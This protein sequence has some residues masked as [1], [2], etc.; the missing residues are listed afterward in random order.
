MSVDDTNEP[1]GSFITMFGRYVA[2]KL[3]LSRVVINVIQ[4]RKKKKEKVTKKKMDISKYADLKEKRIGKTSNVY[5][6]F[7]TS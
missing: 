1:I 2:M 4:K 6:T 3:I 7:I 5:E